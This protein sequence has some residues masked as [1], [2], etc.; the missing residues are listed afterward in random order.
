[1]KTVT[2]ILSLMLISSSVFAGSYNFECTAYHLDKAS[3]EIYKLSM[4]REGATL[5]NYPGVL[6]DIADP[7]VNLLDGVQTYVNTK[8]AITVKATVRST[9]KIVALSGNIGS[10]QNDVE[11]SSVNIKLDRNGSV[12]NFVGS[13]IETTVSTCGGSCN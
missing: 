10:R 4:T 6:L 8:Q 9:R 7:N 3:N 2:T 12:E 13:C 5:D 1:M 11:M